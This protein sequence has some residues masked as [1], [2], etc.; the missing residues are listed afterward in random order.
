MKV[1]IV[2]D[3][4]LAAQRLQLLLKQADP[5]I[6][7]VAILES[8]EESVAYLEQ[9]PHPDLLLLDI[10][11]SDGHSFEIFN[12]ITYK[13]PV[14]FITAFDQYAIEAFRLFSIDYILKPISLESLNKAIAKFR[15]ITD[16]FKAVDY[17]TVLPKISTETANYKSRFLA[18][19]GQRLFFV[20]IKDVAYFQADNKV[21]YLVD[22]EGNRYLIDY[23]L[24]KLES[25]LDPKD[26]FRLNRK[27]I[28]KVSAIEQVRPYFNSRLKLT[29]K[30]VN[31]K[32]EMVVSRE[33]V[34][35]FRSWA[36]A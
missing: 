23:T 1:I 13:G 36:E 29:V 35:E 14:V 18:R 15:A 32:E 5:S 4:L 7:V 33:R 25:L 9:F 11:L 21:V 28:V 17:S 26:F 16:T 3:E 34:A 24:D 10:Q 12:K 6:K 22:K 20:E 19:V 27:F 30:G 31:T 2:E 8:I